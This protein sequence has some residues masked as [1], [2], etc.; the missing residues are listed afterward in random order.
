MKFSIWLLISS[1]ICTVT[2]F[3]DSVGPAI[4]TNLR[5]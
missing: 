2:F 4:F 1:R 3:F 5:L